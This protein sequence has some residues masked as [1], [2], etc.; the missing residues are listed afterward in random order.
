MKSSPSKCQVKLI[1]K[2]NCKC[3]YILSLFVFVMVRGEQGRATFAHIKPSPPKKER[4]TVE[5]EKEK[6]KR[7]EPAGLE[8]RMK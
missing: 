3:N 4:K 6:E 7:L 1:D 8:S 2:T 5:K